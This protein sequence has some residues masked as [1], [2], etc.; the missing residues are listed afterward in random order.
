M[1]QQLARANMIEQ[2]IRPWNVFDPQVLEAMGELQREHFLGKAYEKLAYAD[3]SVPLDNGGETTLPR[4]AGQ[5]A[6]ALAIKPTDKVLEIGT[7][8]GYV[9]ALLARLASHVY[10]M[11]VDAEQL[12]TADRHL[13]H[14]QITNVTLVNGDGLDGDLLHS[15]FDAIAVTGSVTAIPQKLKEQLALGG[16]L[17]A[18][19][20]TGPIMEA[21]LV[22]RT[23]R[24]EWRDR[25]LFET[26]VAPLAG[27]E[28]IAE[29]DF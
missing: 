26:E 15:P 29:F 2:Q 23:E 27:V 28:T 22:T 19:T 16:R 1:N 25:P 21:T 4:I 8:S 10:S 7:G 9:T 3:I 20:G 17:F 24:D 6:Q 14:E 5:M 12:E 13:T 18:I 11:D